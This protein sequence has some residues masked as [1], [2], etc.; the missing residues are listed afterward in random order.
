LEYG[1]LRLVPWVYYQLTFK[2]DGGPISL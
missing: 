1:L 2:A